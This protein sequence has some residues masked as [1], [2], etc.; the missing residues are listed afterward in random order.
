[1]LAAKL[2][3]VLLCWADRLQFQALQRWSIVV[4]ERR[5]MRHVCSSFARR[6]DKSGIWCSWAS[7]T[8]AVKIGH[9]DRCSLT[10]A[11][12]HDSKH[13]HEVKVQALRKWIV[14]LVRSKKVQRL[15]RDHAV[16]FFYKSFL[17]WHSL[18]W[19]SQAKRSI[20]EYAVM[21]QASA[22]VHS[23]FEIWK[24]ATL[25]RLAMDER[26]HELLAASEASLEGAAFARWH[27]GLKAAVLAR[28]NR[29]HKIAKINSLVGLTSRAITSR[30]INSW[31]VVRVQRRLSRAFVVMRRARVERRMCCASVM[32]WFSMC[33]KTNT[34]H[35]SRKFIQGRRIL[36]LKRKAAHSW[37][38]VVSAL[39]ACAGKPQQPM[40]LHVLGF[41]HI[42]VS[43]ASCFASRGCCCAAAIS[44]TEQL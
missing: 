14:L 26:N 34:L 22:E 40:V 39:A 30:F 6:L 4:T 44:P 15:E 17:Q 27:D 25:A 31:A 29:V 11:M 32:I 5:R 18:C 35:R 33:E 23:A 2:H 7:W 21:V 13:L 12:G 43:R 19:R 36:S 41:P 8:T 3:R 28:R 24:E 9:H 37:R 38:I 10:K 20:C 1:M 42:V 16:R